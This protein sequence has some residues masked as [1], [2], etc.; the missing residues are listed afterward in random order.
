LLPGGDSALLRG[1]ASLYTVTS[2]AT[3][4]SVNQLDA[5][6]V[7]YPASIRATYL[8]VPDVPQRVRDL[9]RSLTVN[10]RSPYDK[11]VRIQ[12]YLRTTYRYR[13][14]VPPAPPGQDVVDYFLFDA[15]GGF[16]SYYASA[17][18]VMLRVQGV[19]ARVV[20][21]YAMGDYDSTQRAYRVPA[22]AAHAWVEVY[23]PTLGW[24]E[25]EPTT[26]QAVFLYRADESSPPNAPAPVAPKLVI[27]ISLNVLAI[28]AGLLS[29]IGVIGLVMMFR[30]RRARE[31]RA[32]NQLVD[33]LYWQMRQALRSLGVHAPAC[34]T[35]IEFVA[36]YLNPIE[37][38]PR[39]TAVVGD[40]A[41]QYI[42]ATYTDRPPARADVLLLRR[43]WRGLWVERLRVRWLRQARGIR[44]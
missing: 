4:A 35:P 5:D 12:N 8:R 34:A 13:L 16:C 44:Q 24:V 10:A 41:A 9:S 32:A 19:P 26:S 36:A 23:F 39:L 6:S 11:A 25:F 30:R 21:G 37:N 28:G 1:N 27:A 38:R 20:S 14:D 3:A 17:M 42:A 2:W 33:E 40:I 43:T 7:N 29:V 18:V 31:R 22:S 15:P